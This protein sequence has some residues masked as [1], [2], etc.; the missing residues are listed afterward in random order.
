M[1]YLSFC[2]S[3]V[4]FFLIGSGNPGHQSNQGHQDREVCQD[5]KGTFLCAPVLKVM[6]G[7]DHMS[8]HVGGKVCLCLQDQRIRDTLGLGRGESNSDSKQ[9]T[10]V[11]GNDLVNI[12]FLNFH[13]VQDGYCKVTTTTGLSPRYHVHAIAPSFS[14]LFFPFLPLQV[15]A[16]NELHQMTLI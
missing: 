5:A 9:L 7:K 4:V 15:C 12:S 16:L 13:A 8:V 11:Y 2:V 3:V 6:F 10:I 1:I 14:V